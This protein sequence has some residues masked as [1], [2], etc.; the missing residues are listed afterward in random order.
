MIINKVTI[1]V[2]KRI[3]RTQQKIRIKPRSKNYFF[4][5]IGK[6][7]KWGKWEIGAKEGGRKFKLGLEINS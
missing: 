5:S 6:W 4:V 1:N 7:G 3:W 2:L